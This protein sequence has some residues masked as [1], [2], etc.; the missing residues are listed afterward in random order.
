LFQFI[1]ILLYSEL[2]RYP[3]KNSHNETYEKGSGE[4]YSLSGAPLRSTT[5]NHYQFL[6]EIERFLSML[7]SQDSAKKNGKVYTVFI[8]L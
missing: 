8:L 4:Q 7:H 5:K 3:N 1:N 2:P 6:A